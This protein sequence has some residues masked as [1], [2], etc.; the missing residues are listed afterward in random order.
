[1]FNYAFDYVNEPLDASVDASSKSMMI[2]SNL[3]P[4]EPT[5]QLID[6][7]DPTSP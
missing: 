2:F 1:M 5:T 3:F 7:F 6:S 4:Q